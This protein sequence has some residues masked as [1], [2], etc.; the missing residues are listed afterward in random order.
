MGQLIDVK[1]R[2]IGEVAVFDLDRSLTGQQIEAF[3]EPSTDDSPAGLLTRRLWELD[4]SIASVQILSNTVTVSRR[5]GWDGK[6]LSTVEDVLANLFVHYRSADLDALRAENY[7]ASISWI[8]EHNPDLRVIRIKP[9]KPLE[10]FQ[11]GQYCTLGL[12]YWEPRADETSEDF[13]ANPSQRLKMAR[14]SYSIS[15]SIVSESG[16]LVEP[17]TEEI[18]FYV[19]RVP[20]GI[21]EIPALTPRIFMKGVGERIFLNRKVAGRYTLE[22]VEPTDNV[23]FLATGTGEAPHNQMTAELLRN[24]HQG[25]IISV[26]CVRHRRDLAYLEQHETVSKRWPNYQYVPLTTREP[27]NEGNKVYIQDYI[28]SGVLEEALGEPLDPDRTHV[29]LCGNPSMI[30]LPTWDDDGETMNFPEQ[31]GVC[32]LLHERGFTIDRHK[33]RGNVHYEEYWRDR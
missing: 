5:G 9:D 23:V 8:R 13:S 1:A 10:P 25:K 11:P 32:Q 29:F 26:A 7:N 15:S 28:T 17:N 4:D 18:E 30:G 19:V 3:T 16:D 27:E 22:G 2:I 14:R 6:T 24:G 12:G 31:L 20:P 21:E 33:V